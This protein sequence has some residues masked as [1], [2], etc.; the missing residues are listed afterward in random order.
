MSNTTPN[1]NVAVGVD[2]FIA[3][4]TTTT[5]TDTIDILYAD[6]HPA[7]IHERLQD[8]VF[9]KK[10]VC[11]KLEMLNSPITLWG[12]IQMNQSG[13]YHVE[14]SDQQTFAVFTLKQVSSMGRTSIWITP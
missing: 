4:T 9:T 6:N 7:M 11:V 13:H 2:S 8:M 14:N 1:P 3:T 10:E 5:T 12:V